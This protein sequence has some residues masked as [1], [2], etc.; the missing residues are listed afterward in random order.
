MHLPMKLGGVGTARSYPRTAE[1]VVDKRWGH[2]GRCGVRD[3]LRLPSLIHGALFALAAT[4]LAIP[5][6][7]EG[8]L[9]DH[10]VALLPLTFVLM[11]PVGVAAV[12]WQRKA[13][14]AGLLPAREKGARGLV[15]AL[16]L[17]VACML[18][19]VWLDAGYLAILKEKGDPVLLRLQ[20]PDTVYGAWALLLWGAGFHTLF[21]VAGGL[22]F[23]A[24]L[25]NVLW[26]SIVMTVAVRAV[27]SILRVRDAGMEQLLPD[28]LLSSVVLM[29]IKCLLLVRYGLPAPIVFGVVLDSRHFI[30]LTDWSDT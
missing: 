19:A 17:G 22:A 8:R 6:L 26:I 27:V 30:R 11:F 5:R 28:V 7:Q 23:F 1:P 21:F 15:W 16:V 12:A 18:G 10:L 2:V 4:V 24:R 13:G 25:T 14:M 20:Y 29:T 9:D 3:C